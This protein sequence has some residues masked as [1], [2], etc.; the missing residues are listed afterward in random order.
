MQLVEFAVV[1]C[2]QHAAI[3]DHRRRV[4]DNCLFQQVGQFRISAGNYRQARQV[5]SFELG[6]GV[7]QFRQCAEGVAQACQV[8]WPG[9]AQ[10]DAGK[11]PLDIAD[12]LELRLQL[13]EAIAFE[14]AFDRT[15]P[16]LQY[17][18]VTQRPV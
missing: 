11:D 2:F 5:R 18:Q 14:Q 13:L 12:V 4:V 10:A 6:H 3:A 9:V 1:T 8:A 17:L 7:L 15:L 16:G